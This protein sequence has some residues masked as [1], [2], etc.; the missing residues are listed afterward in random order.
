MK[1]LHQYIT[2]WQTYICH[3][4]WHHFYQSYFYITDTSCFYKGSRTSVCHQHFSCLAGN[5]STTKDTYSSLR[6][7]YLTAQNIMSSSYRVIGQTFDEWWNKRSCTG[8][9]DNCIRSKF[10]NIIYSSFFIE[11]KCNT[12]FISTVCKV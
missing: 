4:L 10:L 9:Y 6:Y 8:S 1:A 12:C 2:V 3:E 11:F 5:F 7:G